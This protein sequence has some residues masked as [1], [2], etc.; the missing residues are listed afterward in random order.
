MNDQTKRA[1][2]L[3]GLD[4]AAVILR[5]VLPLLNREAKKCEACGI[6]R[7]D[8]WA[9]YQ[10]AEEVEGMIRKLEKWQAALKENQHHG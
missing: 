2:V 10:C 8:H 4:A 6:N 9:E 3:A 5:R 7:R 1:L